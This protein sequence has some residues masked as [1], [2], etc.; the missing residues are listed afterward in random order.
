MVSI[1]NGC[2]DI[3]TMRSYQVCLRPLKVKIDLFSGTIVA[4]D[5]ELTKAIK[6]AKRVGCV[7][8]LQVLKNAEDDLW[9]ANGAFGKAYK[10]MT[11]VYHA[12]TVAKVEAEYRKCKAA[13]HVAAKAM[14]E[15]FFW[16]N[17]LALKTC[18]EYSATDK[19]T[20]PSRTSSQNKASKKSST[21]G[22]SKNK[23]TPKKST[24]I[25]SAPVN[26]PVFS[27]KYEGDNLLLLM[28][29]K[30][31]DPA[32]Q[33]LLKNPSYKFERI[34]RS[35]SLRKKIDYECNPYRFSLSFVNGVLTYISFKVMEWD[36]DHYFK[37]KLPLNIPL[38]KPFSAMQGMKDKWNG[39]S[40]NW[41]LVKYQLKF[42]VWGENDKIC[43]VTINAEDVKDWNSYYQ[44]F[45]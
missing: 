10:A 33:K 9:E 32:V 36:K 34:D 20:L 18:Y 21:S 43:I 12:K 11:E 42:N 7:Q 35:G 22:L 4:A 14:D 30:I 31:D 6:E 41:T 19:N 25:T 3:T 8:W 44:Q 27:G 28:G 2:S 5:R 45:Q 16:I 29:R 23:T 15:Y 17:S 37:K 39:N 40:S 24:S 26:Y 13:L 38:A 1:A